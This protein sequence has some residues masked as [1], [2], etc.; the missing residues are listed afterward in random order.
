[1]GE[2]KRAEVTVKGDG[3][4]LVTGGVGALGLHAAH[5]LVANGARRLVLTSRTGAVDA[6]GQAILDSLTRAGASVAVLAADVSNAAEIDAL[7]QLLIANT[8]SPLRGVL[9]MAGVDA[10]VALTAMSAADIEAACAAKVRG[11]WLLHE[12]TQALDLD[13]FV[14]FSSVASI[15]GSQGRAHYGA[16]NAFLDALAAERHRLGLAAT[17]I[18]WGPWQGGGMASAETLQQFERVGNHGLDPGD[19]LHA[20]GRATASGEP[21]SIVADIDWETFRPIYEARR[22]RPL[23][24]S[25]DAAAV[26]ERTDT[27][28]PAAAWV[29]TLRRIEPAV[30]EAELTRLLQAEVA[31]TLGFADVESVGADKSFYQ[32]GMDSLLM[33]DLVGR[34]KKR[35]GFSCSAL[36]FDHPNVRALA[37]KLLPRLDAGDATVRNP[38]EAANGV[39]GY[40]QAVEAEILAF[41]GEAFPER[42]V[43]LV[44]DRWRWMFLDSARRL[45]VEPRVWV[46]RD[47]GRIV[48]Q[49]GSIPVRLKLGDEERQTGWLVETMVL[50]EHRSQAVGSRLI[51]QAHEDQP[52]SLSLGQTAEAREILFHLGWKQIAPLRIAQLLVR[53]ENV[54]KGKLPGPAAWAAGLGLRATS[55]V[56]GLFTEPSSF[57]ERSVDRFDERHDRLWQTMAKDVTCGVVRDASYLNWKYVD[58]PG[59]DFLRLELSDASG[60]RAVAVWML[61]EPDQ[62]YRYRRAFL[63]DL[64]TPLAGA[65]ALQ[66]VVR[67]S[68]DVAARTGVDAL[69]CH[70]IGA[71]LTSALQK[72]GFRLRQPERFLVAD[73]APLLEA[74]R[75]QVQ[76]AD[77][78]FVTQGDSDIDRPW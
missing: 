36:I 56:R 58:Q 11:A 23:L 17:T 22:A 4:Y 72:S 53:P 14:C 29:E 9:H 1:M 25:L 24:A 65:A 55:T 50:K 32:I 5:W 40:S 15:L 6:A 3:T 20:L 46:Y 38:E 61:R 69:L 12:G 31:E 66:Q 49:M 52:A 62:N 78:W 68:C 51:V 60:V 45:A 41:Q 30:R 71:P 76:D 28:A 10:P 26:R 7:L 57:E 18:N 8:A 21:Q 2:A 13:L 16:A 33:A 54:L 42:R 34:L 19:A 39:A 67:A 47:Q 75:R 35:V 63:V 27:T 74:A 77:G 48:G 37:A 44:P 43:E 64:V 59:Q 70:H 73:T